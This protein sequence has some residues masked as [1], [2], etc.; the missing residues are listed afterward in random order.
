[1]FG[2]VYQ[3][4]NKNNGKIYIG[5]TTET[6]ARRWIRHCYKAAKGQAGCGKLYNAIRKHGP[7]SFVLHKLA[8]ASDR[9]GLDALETFYIEKLDAVAMGYNIS[10]I[11]RVA[12]ISEEGKQKLREAVVGQAHCISNVVRTPENKAKQVASMKA[13]WLEMGYK[14]TPPRGPKVHRNIWQLNQT[15]I[16]YNGFVYQSFS[17]FCA[18]HGIVLDNLKAR[19]LRAK[20]KI[21]DQVLF[22][23]DTT[24]FEIPPYFNKRAN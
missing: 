13:T 2:C 12:V 1:M 19:L 4:T 22:D 10:H 20:I 21:S 16:H 15:L 23:L 17:V 7:D 3:I 6:M 18:M 8:E 14:P 9:E 24:P 5:Q 11:A